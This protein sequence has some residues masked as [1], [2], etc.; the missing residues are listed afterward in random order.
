MTQLDI[1][2]VVFGLLAAISG[3]LR[4]ASFTRVDRE[5]H[6]RLKKLDG[7]KLPLFISTFVFLILAAVTQIIQVTTKPSLE[8]TQGPGGRILE[9]ATLT[10][11]EKEVEEALSEQCSQTTNYFKAAEHDFAAGLYGDA[12]NS[13]QKSIS[14]IAQ[15][16]RM[17]FTQYLIRTKLLYTVHLAQNRGMTG[18]AIAGR[19]GFSGAR[20]FYRCFKRKLGISFS[21]YRG[22]YTSREFEQLYTRQSNPVSSN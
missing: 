2:G 21:T 18:M 17:P 10:G 15:F 9:K 13:Y 7:K 12:V 20:E 11:F 22:K 14:V 1:L 16:C 19:C 6:P 8:Q 5:K 3:L 4:G